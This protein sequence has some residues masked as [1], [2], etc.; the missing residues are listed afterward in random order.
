MRSKID[1]SSLLLLAFTI[2][3]TLC[4]IEVGLRF[5]ERM[6]FASRSFKILNSP[7]AP[8]DKMAGGGLYYSHPYISYDMKPG[9]KYP[10]EV[11]INSLGFRGK[12]FFFKKPAG[13][14][15]IVAIGGSTTYGSFLDDSQTYPYY[16]EKELH[17]DLN[18]DKIEVINAGLV[19]ATS[20]ESLTRFL[21]KIVPLEPDMIIYYEG[22]ND[23]VP[24]IFN[25]F[26]DDYYHFR[27]NP[28]NHL[29]FLDNFYLYRLIKSGFHASLFHPNT[30]LLSYI[31]KF[32]N[33]PND[34]VQKIENFNKNSSRTY[35][36]NVD[37][38]ITIARAK[39][40]TVV[41]STFPYNKESPNW[42]DYMPKILWAKGIA[43]N[44]AVIENLASRYQLPLIHFYDYALLHKNIFHDSIHMNAEGN[45]EL[46]KFFSK[47]L[48]PIISSKM[49]ITSS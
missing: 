30:T 9:Y 1:K 19:S 23:L 49:K 43:E 24:R 41:L 21:F 42:N 17:K 33:M 39:N 28:Q 40:I 36:R 3:I 47:T 6:G 5:L 22:Y 37:Y 8:F 7:Y 10:G 2:I 48:I 38:I 13:T 12:E 46:A 35:E 25:N 27:K 4:S 31:W 20:A 34:D 15:R 32:E 16:L 26:S 44:N 14:Y 11:S 29:S 18:T 45:K